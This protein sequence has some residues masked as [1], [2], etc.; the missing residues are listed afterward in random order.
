[1][2]KRLNIDELEEFLID[3]AE[4]HR[5]YPNDRVW[6]NIN[7]ELHGEK[8]WPALT[9]G[10]IL[11]GAI[12]TAGLIL[13]HPDRDLF[14]IQQQVP[15]V[16]AENGT[17]TNIIVPDEHVQVPLQ[18]HNRKHAAYASGFGV[19]VPA[20]DVTY[21][22][23][24]GTATASIAS[25]TPANN[26]EQVINSNGAENN[27]GYMPPVTKNNLHAA[28]PA[29]IAENITAEVFV[30]D[31]DPETEIMAGTNTVAETAAAPAKQ[32][33]AET[34]ED[35]SV[36]DANL[37]RGEW[38]SKKNKQNRWSSQFYFTPSISYR[39][40]SEQKYNDP[41][42]ATPGPLAVNR[43]GSVNNFVNHRSGLGFEAGGAVMYQLTS[44]FRI[45]A[46]VQLNLRQYHIEAF[47]SPTEATTLLINRGPL[48][49]SVISYSNI[50]NLSGYQT[51]QVTNRYL[52]LAVPVGFDLR[53]AQSK[54]IDLYVSGSIQP[55]YQFNTNQYL[56]ST[57]YKNY[58]QQPDLVR[59]W[60]LNSGLEAF[61]TYKGK[62][63]T[64]WQIGPQL[65]YQ[66]LA[67][68]NRRY[69]IQEKLIDFG[70]KVGVVK[71]LH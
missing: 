1:M 15:V 49:D 29:N 7:Q 37:V 64:S 53:L 2:S 4:Q 32:F 57:D 18:P 23:A 30:R 38:I 65:R 52:Q 33:A 63:G 60:N 67:G 17:K 47:A 34:F 68:T 3:N 50:R 26:Y 21:D 69:P 9:F 16:A 8:R 58:T 55:T 6:R 66:L 71:S 45:K 19:T 31:N 11:T 5:M 42:Y 44:N 43:S 62:N 10:A 48:S 20:A 14:T 59:R 36:N 51:T 35:E 22:A 46:G 41:H 39:S 70:L 12:I 28:A 27:F 54:K 56:L 25:N 40:L 13:V 61:V 24:I